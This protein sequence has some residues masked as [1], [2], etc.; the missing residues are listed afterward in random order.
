MSAFV[1]YQ[2]TRD[3][4]IFGR[5]EQPDTG[6]SPGLLDARSV[7]RFGLRTLA[8]DSGAR[9]RVPMR[10]LRNT[11]TPVEGHYQAGHYL[12]ALDFGRKKLAHLRMG[13]Y[14]T[15]GP[16]SSSWWYYICLPGYCRNTPHWIHI[17]QCQSCRP[18]MP[19]HPW[20]RISRL[21]YIPGSE[22]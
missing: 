19:P 6:T 11:I 1:A 16:P 22:A 7:R 9:C 2:A 13:S 15:I 21:P 18:S 4:F 20:S 3:G 10:V 8:P 5:A 12:V 17:H 14:D